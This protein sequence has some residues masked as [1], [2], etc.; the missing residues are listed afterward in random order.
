MSSFSFGFFALLFKNDNTVLVQGQQGIRGNKGEAENRGSTRQFSLNDGIKFQR[1]KLTSNERE[2]RRTGL[3]PELLMVQ[4]VQPALTRFCSLRPVH[5]S[6]ISDSR[7]N[8]NEIEN[9]HF[10]VAFLSRSEANQEGIS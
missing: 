9:A 6:L 3:N 10:L 2:S 8:Q 7:P 1:M 4:A 5:S